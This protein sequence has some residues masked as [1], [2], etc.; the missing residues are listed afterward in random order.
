[1]SGFAITAVV[2][3][4]TAKLSHRNSTS[5][6][7]RVVQAIDSP[8]FW[9][10]WVLT[11]VLLITMI[12][13]AI[14]YYCFYQCGFVS[15]VGRSNTVLGKVEEKAPNKMMRMIKGGREIDEVEELFEYDSKW[16]VKRLHRNAQRIT[17]NKM[18]KAINSTAKKGVVV[19]QETVSTTLQSHGFPNLPHSLT[20]KATSSPKVG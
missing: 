16:F 11:G 19:F 2:A 8:G 10:G 15:F 20:S 7:V 4:Y 1:M 5:T 18:A 9:A 6:S 12:Y 14:L 17:N 13:I 3:D